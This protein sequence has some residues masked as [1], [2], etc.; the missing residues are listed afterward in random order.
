VKGN[1]ILYIT[2]PTQ[3]IRENYKI[4]IDLTS[5][6][7]I[8]FDKYWSK[9]CSGFYLSIMKLYFLFSIFLASTL[10]LNTSHSQQQQNSPT[11]LPAIISTDCLLQDSLSTLR[12]SILHSLEEL[13]PCSC[14]G[15]GWTRVA[16]L[17]MAD[18]LQ[19]CCSAWTLNASP[20]RKCR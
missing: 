19:T 7:P 3:I 1:N 11:H 20:V 17:N 9:R 15:A 5:S 18:P 14:G 2:P 10:N 4:A 8:G 13:R 12:R 16:Y 6:S